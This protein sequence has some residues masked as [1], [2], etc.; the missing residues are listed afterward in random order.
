[1]LVN[2]PYCH[3]ANLY[4]LLGSRLSFIITPRLV[5]LPLPLTLEKGVQDLHHEHQAATEHDER[6]H[7]QDQTHVQVRQAGLTEQRVT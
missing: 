1:M 6:D 3:I 4:Q 2:T 5:P 7:Q